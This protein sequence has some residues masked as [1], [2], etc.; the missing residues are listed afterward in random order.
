MLHLYKT[1]TG[2]LISSATVIDL[3]PEGM[4]V[5]ESDKKGVWNTST[6][7]FEEVTQDKVLSRDDFLDLFT[8][9]EMLLIVQTANT[10]TNIKDF[11]DVLNFRGRVRMSSS[12][13]INAVNYM[14]SIGLIAEGRAN[15]VLNG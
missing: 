1:E 3:I 12:T 9:A 14:A 6:L 10:D 5:K 13:T 8:D 7:D 11:L 4:A 2:V 15:E